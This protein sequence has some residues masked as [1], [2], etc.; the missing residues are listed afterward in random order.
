MPTV[1]LQDA[2]RILSRAEELFQPFPVELVRLQ[3]Y[4]SC[5]KRKKGDDRVTEPTYPLPKITPLDW[6]LRYAIK[7]VKSPSESTWMDVYY[8]IQRHANNIAQ[9]IS[10]DGKFTKGYELRGNAFGVPVSDSF[11]YKRIREFEVR[12]SLPVDIKFQ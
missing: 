12:F 5:T 8:G 9:I 4:F 7:P 1:P 2:R 10:A 3:E 11:G 6:T